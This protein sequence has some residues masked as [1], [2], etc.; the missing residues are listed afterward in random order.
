MKGGVCAAYIYQASSHQC[1]SSGVMGDGK[2]SGHGHVDRCATSSLPH[3]EAKMSVKYKDI[4]QTNLEFNTKYSLS[5]LYI[6][7]NKSII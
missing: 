2:V 6:Y 1:F 4:N 3:E 7:I 5:K